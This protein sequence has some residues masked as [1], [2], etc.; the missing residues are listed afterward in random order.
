VLEHSIAT[1]PLLLLFT[2]TVLCSLYGGSILGMA[3]AVAA[4]SLHNYFFQS[5]RY[6]FAVASVEDFFELG[7]FL[8]MALLVSFV[9]AQIRNAQREAELLRQRAEDAVQ[10]RDDLLAVVTHDLR[11]PLSAV[12]LNTAV[13]RRNQPGGLTQASAKALDMIERVSQR[14]LRLI[15]DLLDYEKIKAGNFDV[16]LKNEPLRTIF[17][18]LEATI[19][20]LTSAK[21]QT[22]EF[23]FP[24]AELVIPCDRDRLTQAFLNLLGN[25][26]KFTAPG[27]KLSV[28]YTADEREIEF[29]VRDTGPGIPKEQVTRVFD[30]YWQARQTAR[31]GTGLGLSIAK[32]IV[33]GHHG[34][35]WLKSRVGE[36]TTFYF[37]LPLEAPRAGLE[38]RLKYGQTDKREKA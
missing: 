2:A 35:I 23:N 36:G 13:I 18:E 3:S 37:A 28:G 26:V 29:F 7:L 6:S 10:S 4:T 5:P 31:Q 38:I 19:E 27:G 24:P 9:S 11:N 14:M 8:A 25:A 30:R 15:A 21:S 17:E 20:P 16:E 33:E 12:Q 34:R 32:G 22:L 1:A